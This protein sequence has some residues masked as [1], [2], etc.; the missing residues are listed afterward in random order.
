MLTSTTTTPDGRATYTYERMFPMAEPWEIQVL[1]LI[2][3]RARTREEEITK[4]LVL[5]GMNMQEAKA[6]AESLWSLPWGMVDQYLRLI[7]RRSSESMVVFARG[8]GKTFRGFHADEMLPKLP[9]S[10]TKKMY[11][12]VTTGR[13]LDY[14]LWYTKRPVILMSPE[15]WRAR[16]ADQ[17]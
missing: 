11:E 1:Y 13:V 8:S 4:R 7:E 6:V 5:V 14:A 9:H 17:T 16:Y 3:K 15:E 10:I 2:M 12:E